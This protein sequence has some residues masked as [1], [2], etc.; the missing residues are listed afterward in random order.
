MQNF[1]ETHMNKADEPEESSWTYYFDEFVCKNDHDIIMSSSNETLNSLIPDATSAVVKKTSCFRDD[2]LKRLSFKKRKTEGVVIDDSLED[3]ASSPLSSPK[4]TYFNQVK[5]KNKKTLHASEE[6]VGKI[7]EQNKRK[8][9]SNLELKK[10]GLCLV[11]L[12]A[13]ANYLP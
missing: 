2:Q 8:A 11:P 5:I 10:R 3:T 1:Q 6:K 13:L 4:V 9:I 7:E 12:S